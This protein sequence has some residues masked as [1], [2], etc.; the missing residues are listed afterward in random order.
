M[1]ERIIDSF[2]LNKIFLFIGS[3]SDTNTETESTNGLT[4]ITTPINNNEV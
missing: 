3:T 4:S 1:V 2:F